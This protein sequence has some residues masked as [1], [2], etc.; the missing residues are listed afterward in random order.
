MT[1][2]CCEISVLAADK[3]RVAQLELL[4]RNPLQWRAVHQS[5]PSFDFAM[6]LTVSRVIGEWRQNTRFDD[7]EFVASSVNCFESCEFFNALGHKAG[8]DLENGILSLRE[9]L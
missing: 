4:P 2:R 1:S 9:R 5:E 8:P 6:G 3:H 7:F